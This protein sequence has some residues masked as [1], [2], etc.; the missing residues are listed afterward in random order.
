M[1]ERVYHR[2]S[3]A[4]CHMRERVKKLNAAVRKL[5]YERKVSNV[6]FFLLTFSRI[7]TL[8]D[9]SAADRFFENSDKEEI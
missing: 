6:A 2:S 9:V 5:L 3:A 4:E 7:E 8:S 1:R